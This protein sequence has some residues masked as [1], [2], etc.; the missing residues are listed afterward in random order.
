MIT[1]AIADDHQMFTDGIQ[2]LLG[3]YENISCIGSAQT[4]AEILEFIKANHPDVLLLDINMPGNKNMETLEKIHADFPQLKVLMLSMH[5]E[6]ELI[7]KA[8]ESGAH[9]FILKDASVNE[10][11]KA[12]ESVYNGNVYYSEKVTHSIMESLTGTDNKN[13]KQIELTARERDVLQLIVNENTTQ[14]IADKLFISQSTV[15]THRRNLL[16]KTESRNTAGLVKFALQQGI[17]KE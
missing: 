16:R 2:L 15:I 9:G 11:G 10:L 3:T 1:V 5:S 8:I 4:G 7:R 6:S 13:E 14:E 12:I 17:Y